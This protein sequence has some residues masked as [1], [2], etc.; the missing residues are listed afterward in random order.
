MIDDGIR[1]D[2]GDDEEKKWRRQCEKE[3]MG[4]IWDNV[5]VIR[6]KK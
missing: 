1:G 2:Y 5:F 4:I 3:R 6:G